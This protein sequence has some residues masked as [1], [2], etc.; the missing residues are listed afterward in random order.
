MRGYGSEDDPATFSDMEAVVLEKSGKGGAAAKETIQ[1]WQARY[2]R[3]LPHIE[4][5]E[6]VTTGLARSAVRGIPGAHQ[7]LRLSCGG[8]RRPPPAQAESWTG[9][10]RWP[11]C[12]AAA[13]AS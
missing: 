12:A 2:R 11:A 7:F 10:A 5:L 1:E 9:W 4:H 8:C 3:Q 13:T 6:Q